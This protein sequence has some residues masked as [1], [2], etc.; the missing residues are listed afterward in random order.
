MDSEIS[1]RKVRAHVGE[2]GNERADRFA[3]EAAE[4][5]DLDFSYSHLPRTYVDLILEEKSLEE[6]SRLW[7]LSSRGDRTKKL[8]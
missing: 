4:S 7:S 6:W 2:V 5:R 3:K 1:F 8:N